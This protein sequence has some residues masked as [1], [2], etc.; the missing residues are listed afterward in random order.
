MFVFH[1]FSLVLIQSLKFQEDTAVL[2]YNGAIYIELAVDGIQ[3]S[4][5]S[6]VYSISRSKRIYYRM[7]MFDQL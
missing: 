1:H 3:I 7:K 6:N 2:P 5:T 4:S